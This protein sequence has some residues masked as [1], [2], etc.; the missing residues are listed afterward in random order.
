VRQQMPLRTAIY[1][2]IRGAP[3]VLLPIA[4]II[5]NGSRY[6]L[7]R[8]LPCTLIGYGDGLRPRRK[9]GGRH[10]AGGQLRRAISPRRWNFPSVAAL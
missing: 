4:F 6:P 9:R 3:Y 2:G 8:P 7:A 1:D 5:A 10:V